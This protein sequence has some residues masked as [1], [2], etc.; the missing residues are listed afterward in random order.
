MAINVHPEAELTFEPAHADGR[1][2][3]WGAGYDW[4]FLARRQD[5]ATQRTG[6]SPEWEH[7]GTEIVPGLDVLTLKGTAGL[8]DMVSDEWSIH[9]GQGYWRLEKPDWGKGKWWWSY[10]DGRANRIGTIVADYQ[11]SPRHAFYT[12]EFPPPADQTSRVVTVLALLGDPYG[13]GIYLPSHDPDY[14][15]PTLYRGHIGDWTEVDVFDRVDAADGALVSQVRR[16]VVWIEETDGALVIRMSG[17]SEPWIYKTPDDYPIPTA[18]WPAVSFEGHCGMFNTPRIWYPD[19]E[20][21]TGTCTSRKWF[22]VPSYVNWTPNWKTATR[23]GDESYVD[24][25]A[26]QLGN[27]V[28]PEI[29]LTNLGSH[30]RPVVYVVH[31]YHEATLTSPVVDQ[32]N[33]QTRATSLLGAGQDSAELIE[34]SWT[35][36]LWR[37]W[38]F[39]ALI[40]DPHDYWSARLKKNALVTVRG[41]WDGSLSQIMVG[42]LREAKPEFIKEENGAVLGWRLLGADYITARLMGKK[43]TVE[44]CSPE[45][46]DL[47]EYCEWWLGRCGVPS[48]LMSFTNVP[49]VTVRR[50]K[51]KDRPWEFTHDTPIVKALDDLLLAH[52]CHPLAIT[53]LGVIYSG[54]DTGYGGSPDY[55][56]D[57][58][59]KTADEHIRLLHSDI[60]DTDFRN[61][62]GVV[63]DSGTLYVAIDTDSVQDDSDDKYTGDDWW[64]V[65]QLNDAQNPYARLVE[66][67]R[68]RLKS[69]RVAVWGRPLD[70]TL[71]PGDYVLCQVNTDIIPNNAV[72]RVN[73][74]HAVLRPAAMSADVD[75]TMEMEE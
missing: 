50:T 24:V 20:R 2:A 39:E 18:C 17:A 34:L 29:E 16:R 23:E 52:G 58:S 57:Q 36:E 12:I 19:E 8:E 49:S 62:T 69:S 63:D 15:F 73:K 41:G 10:K 11:V 33:T 1:V 60:D 40:R 35:R 7:D 45:G 56:L 70:T 75:Y 51:L 65:E 22:P 66:L 30:D 67:H 21:N 9:E 5:E 47:A 37:P 38:T 26:L 55:T 14:K 61:C 54:L 13:Y 25:T 43:F 31:Q 74:D 44:P 4:R 71:E 46:W 27:E 6:F 72:M 68:D 53:N 59:V 42:Y 3:Q 32:V 64:E 28:K 48:N